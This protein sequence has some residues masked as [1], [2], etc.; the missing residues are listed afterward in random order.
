MAKINLPLKVA[1]GVEWAKVVLS[2]FDHFL[3][4]HAACERKAA[5]LAMSFVAKY[6]DRKAL[7]EPMISLAREELEHFAQVFRLLQTRKLELN[8]KD[9]KDIY[10]N[11][12]LSELRH[13]RDERF[14]DRLI[15]S[16]IVE[17]RGHERFMILAQNLDDENLRQFYFE[18]SEREAGHYKIFIKIAKH[19][20]SEEEVAEAVDRITDIEAKAILSTPLRAVLH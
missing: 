20:F 17:A 14:L 8:N 19:Y 5:A 10:I 13:G 12:I 7:I 15:M 18:L 3:L 9:E 1:T 11:T 4:D 16:G 2:D 6:P